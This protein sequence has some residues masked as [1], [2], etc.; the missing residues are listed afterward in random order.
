MNNKQSTKDLIWNSIR[1]YLRI[2]HELKV[3]FGSLITIDRGQLP[4]S[5]YAEQLFLFGEKEILTLPPAGQ[6]ADTKNEMIERMSA[7]RFSTYKPF[8][9]SIRDAHLVGSYAVAITSDRK[10]LTENL[11]GTQHTVLALNP[12]KFITWSFKKTEQYYDIVFS[13]NNPYAHNFC[14]WF[15]DCLPCL[16]AYEIYRENTNEQPKLLVPGF[17]F[18]WQKRSL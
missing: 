15:N 5:R 8:V 1:R 4:D 14:I 10:I 13:I 9:C 11:Y 6:F 18:E 7:G 12:Y 17:L 3:K 16:Y 2:R